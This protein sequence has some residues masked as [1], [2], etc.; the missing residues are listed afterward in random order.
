MN[1]ALLE[2]MQKVANSASF[3]VFI[4]S[5]CEAY[6]V[7]KT[8]LAKSGFSIDSHHDDCLLGKK[9]HSILF[10]KTKEIKIAHEIERESRQFRYLIIY[11]DLEIAAYDTK[12][13]TSFRC[14]H[15]DFP[16]HYEFFDSFLNQYVT[17]DDQCAIPNFTSDSIELF[18]ELT[19]NN[20]DGIHEYGDFIAL[21]MRIYYLAYSD[22]KSNKKLA[23]FLLNKYTADED[24][25][26]VMWQ[27]CDKTP[28]TSEEARN[29]INAVQTSAPALFD[30]DLAHFEWTI[31]SRNHVRSL[32][33]INWNTVTTDDFGVNS[34]HRA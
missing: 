33:K 27:V 30:K 28:S 10:K 29:L 22:S 12:K 1:D 32:F 23:Q 16:N 7:S 25:D 3:N 13:N 14:F 9:D 26:S 18:S 19:K 15:Q 2:K 31:K 4:Q 11:T 6:S 21:M 20:Y 5:F 34:A 17:K 24:F 8:T